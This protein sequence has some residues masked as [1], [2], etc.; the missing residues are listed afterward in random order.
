MHSCNFDHPISA[1]QV[2]GSWK[3]VCYATAL[4]SYVVVDL[5][6]Y[7]IHLFLN[8]LEHFLQQ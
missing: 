8:A 7:V 6:R 5:C 2:V 1:P 3:A 4:P